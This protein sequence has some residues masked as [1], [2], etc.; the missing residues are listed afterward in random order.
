MSG[1]MNCCSILLRR[2]YGPFWINIY[3]SDDAG[4]GISE[5]NA[6]IWVCWWQGIDA[7]PDLVKRCVRSIRDNAGTHPVHLL[8]KNN[9]TEFLEVPEY[10]LK[11]VTDGQMNLAHFADYIRVSLLAKYGG[12]WLDSTI[13]V[14][15]PVPDSIFYQE[16]FTPKSQPVLNPLYIPNGRWATFCIGGRKNAVLFDFLSAAYEEYWLNNQTAVDYLFFDNL[17]ELA[18]QNIP[19]VKSQLDALPFNNQHCNSLRDAMLADAPATEFQSCI[20]DDTI[21]Y[22]LSWKALY[23]LKTPDGEDTVYRYFLTH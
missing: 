15:K 17:I 14:S 10:I 13:F 19:A 4:E 21:F 2:K 20:Y 16:I 18:Y 22:K 5:E 7:A 9:Y 8:D 23:G 11:K 1:R 12:L 6:P 3:I